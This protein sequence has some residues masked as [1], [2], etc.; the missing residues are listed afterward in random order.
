MTGRNL[1]LP[2]V[3]TRQLG[4]DRLLQSLLTVPEVLSSRLLEEYFFV[5]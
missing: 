3:V 1:T 2:V 5:S 4:L